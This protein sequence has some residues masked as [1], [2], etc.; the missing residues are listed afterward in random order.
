M[1]NAY[2]YDDIKIEYIFFLYAFLNIN[3][4]HLKQ[5]KKKKNTCLLVWQRWHFLFQFLPL[6]QNRVRCSCKKNA[7]SVKT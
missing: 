5:V 6:S 7:F 3:M 4:V 1:F 2:Y